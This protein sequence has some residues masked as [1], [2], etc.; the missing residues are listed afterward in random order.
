M[1]W[2]HGILTPTQ[3]SPNFALLF[4]LSS[5]LMIL[6][7]ASSYYEYNRVKL[8]VNISV[9]LILFFLIYVK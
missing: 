4:F 5:F 6:I 1:I 9:S 2:C 3:E 7:F 8:S